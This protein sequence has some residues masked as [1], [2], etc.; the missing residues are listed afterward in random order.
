M[1][2]ADNAEVAYSEAYDAL[3]REAY[4]TA[5]RQHLEEASQALQE[6]AA[7][8]ESGDDTGA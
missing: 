3:D 5:Y 6:D 4:Y 1:V 7:T 8:G 2:A